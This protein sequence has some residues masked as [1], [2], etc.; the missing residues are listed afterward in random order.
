MSK[1][2]RLQDS[3]S[4]MVYGVFKSRVNTHG[5]SRGYWRA[6]KKLEL[7]KKDMLDKIKK[8]KCMNSEMKV[9]FTCNLN[10]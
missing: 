2:N 10:M 8:C 9:R 3:N 7:L 1:W 4:E 5:R 6:S